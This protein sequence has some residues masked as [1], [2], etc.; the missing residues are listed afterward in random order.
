MFSGSHLLLE[1]AFSPMTIRFYILQAHYTSPVDFS[2]I[3]FN[4]TKLFNDLP[5]F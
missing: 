5:I 3:S 2:N 1:K 4:V